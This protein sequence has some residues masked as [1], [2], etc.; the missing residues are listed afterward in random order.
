MSSERK[1]GNKR[2]KDSAEN[3]KKEDNMCW[4]WGREGGEKE[5]ERERWES[6]RPSCSVLGTLS[7]V[8][9]ARVNA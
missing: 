3:K 1:E 9:R 7:S 2:P 5:R 4:F 6:H 8:L